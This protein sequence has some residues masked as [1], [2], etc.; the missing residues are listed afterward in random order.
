MSM[1]AKLE[2]F[3]RAEVELDA[4]RRDL[5]LEVLDVTD[6]GRENE[7][8]E[9]DYPKPQAIVGT[10]AIKVECAEPGDYRV[11]LQDCHVVVVDPEDV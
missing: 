3:T 6:W 11:E 5:A 8:H 1:R 2:R 7:V 9:R 4:A 10:V